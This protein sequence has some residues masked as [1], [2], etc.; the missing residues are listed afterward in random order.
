MKKK[1]DLVKQW[2][3]KAENDLV[4]AK[5]CLKIKPSPPFDTICFHAQQTAEKYLKS[6]LTF[7]DIEFEKTHDITE[8]ISLASTVDTNFLELLDEAKK[9][10][11]YAVNIRNSMPI[12]E[13]TEQEA[14]ESIKMAEK[15]KEFVLSKLPIE[16]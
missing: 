12:E 9:L 13:P 5:H 8:L 7:H 3:K 15:I 14:K 2:I 1:I 10:T 16:E 4:T 6:F 11:P